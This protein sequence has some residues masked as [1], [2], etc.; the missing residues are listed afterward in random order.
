MPENEQK[1]EQINWSIITKPR[2][3]AALSYLYIM[4]GH[5]SSSYQISNS[6]NL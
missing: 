2:F 3:V 5:Q 6:I 4:P 1:S